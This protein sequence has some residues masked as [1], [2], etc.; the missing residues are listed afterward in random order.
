MEK[1]NLFVKRLFGCKKFCFDI[2]K[3]I[4]NLG[5]IL[6]KKYAQFI[7]EYKSH[8]KMK[9]AVFFFLLGIISILYILV[10][11]DRIF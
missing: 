7:E 8:L 9:K 4:F 3:S 5:F 1:T 10:L 2:R 6:V 11:C